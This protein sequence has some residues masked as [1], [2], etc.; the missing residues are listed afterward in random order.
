MSWEPG[1]TTKH[2]D[3]NLYAELGI[4]LILRS[5]TCASTKNVNFL[6]WIA[7]QKGVRA[8]S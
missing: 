3:D 2:L 8:H 7:A 6:V 1:I 4:M 5:Y